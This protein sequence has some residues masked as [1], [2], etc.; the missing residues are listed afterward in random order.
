MPSEQLEVLFQSSHPLPVGVRGLANRGQ[1]DVKPKR[2]NASKTLESLTRTV[3]LGCSPV[4]K[5]T[6]FTNEANEDLRRFGLA[7][8]DVPQL[9]R[10]DNSFENVMGMLLD[11]TEPAALVAMGYGEGHTYR[12]LNQRYGGLEELEAEVVPQMVEQMLRQSEK[13]GQ[14]AA[15]SQFVVQEK[16]G[17]FAILDMYKLSR[18]PTQK[19]PRGLLD[20]KRTGD[21]AQM[22]PRGWGFAAMLFL[23]ES[24]RVTLQHY[25]LLASGLEFDFSFP[26]ALA[27]FMRDLSPNPNPRELF[28]AGSNLIEMAQLVAAFQSDQAIQEVH[29]P[30]FVWGWNPGLTLLEMLGESQKSRRLLVHWGD[31]PRVDVVVVQPDE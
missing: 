11:M 4:P 17:R 25:R 13:P 9:T 29:C 15:D 1:L 5:V 21:A 28:L 30:D 19:R 16:P 7:I 6:C 10:V 24:P 27:K 22:A 18:K 12:N 8:R 14:I 2:L 3:T 23:A 31:F 20:A 26:Q